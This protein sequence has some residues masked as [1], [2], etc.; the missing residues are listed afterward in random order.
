MILKQLKF[1]KLGNHWYLDIPHDHPEDLVLDDRLERF[2]D[3][4][5]LNKYGTVDRIYLIEEQRTDNIDNLIQFRDEDLLRYFTTTDNFWMVVYIG[6]H[7]FQISSKFY[8]LL[9][10]EYEFNFHQSIYRIIV[11]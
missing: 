2:L 11:Y 10:K 8:Y 5:D 1:K 4:L 6:K 9:E 3:T 7:R